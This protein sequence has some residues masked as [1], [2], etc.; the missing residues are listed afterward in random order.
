M[1]RANEPAYPVVHDVEVGEVS[2]R[3]RT[4]SR[5]AAGLTIRELAAIAA[6]QAILTGAVT[7]GCSSNE[8]TDQEMSVKVADALI[9]EL[10]KEKP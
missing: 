9:A 8:W 6:M 5:D 2:G 4:V 3:V 10:S 1:S 7:R